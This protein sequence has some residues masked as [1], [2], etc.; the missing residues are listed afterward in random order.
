MDKES[1][2]G[3]GK[4]PDPGDPKRPD[5]TGSGSATLI[6]TQKCINMYSLTTKTL[7]KSYFLQLLKTQRSDKNSPENNFLFYKLSAKVVKWSKDYQQKAKT[8]KVTQ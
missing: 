3:S 7:T 5:P 2:S 4:I 6:K 8:D 1:G